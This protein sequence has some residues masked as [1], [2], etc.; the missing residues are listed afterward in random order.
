[1]SDSALPCSFK[2]VQIGC[3]VVGHAYARAFVAANHDVVGIE[4]SHA[5]INQ[6]GSA[7]PMRHVDDDLSDVRDVDFILL[8]INTPLDPEKGALN[9]KYIWSSLRNVTALLT[10]SPN[11]LVVVRSTVT[12]GF[13]AN[14]QQQLCHLLNR[15]HVPLC[16]Q[17]EFL[18]A[19][20][21]LA[22]ALNPWHV[23]VGTD[24]VGD[25][26]KYVRFQQC[27]VEPSRISICTIDEAEIM[28]IFH[29][30]FNAAKISFFNQAGLLVDKIKSRDAKSIDAERTFKLIG[31]TCEGLLNPNYGLTPGHAY[32]GTC[33]PKDSAELAHMEEEYGMKCDFFRQV[34]EVNNVMRGH[35]VS[36]VLH[37]DNHVENTVFLERSV[38]NEK[39]LK[40][41]VK[42]MEEIML[43]QSEIEEEEVVSPNSVK[44]V[45]ENGI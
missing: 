26:K 28:K 8:S 31:R 36:E 32:Y 19:K 21:A 29:N 13:C 9:M 45:I 42:A 11:A 1:M 35:D 5:R 4:A 3:G 14:Y 10:A 44:D 37:G 38:P 43:A 25:V 16:F 17:P 12:I 2:V 20:S 23:V 30:S 24:H 39:P 33:L 15:D 34:V 27:F 7:Y 6:I 18:R 40:I 41:R 22:D